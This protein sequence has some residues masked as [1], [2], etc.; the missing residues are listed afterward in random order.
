M[1]IINNKNNSTSTSIE[2][3]MRTLNLQD[4]TNPPSPGKFHDHPGSG[5]KN[6]FLIYGNTSASAYLTLTVK[7]QK[8]NL[9]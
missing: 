6:R 5:H 7:Y 4:P 2:I 8:Q 9:T 1:V 3:R